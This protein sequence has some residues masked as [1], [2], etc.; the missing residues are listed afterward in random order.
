MN[1]IILTLICLFMAFLLFYAVISVRGILE[2]LTG[3]RIIR[4]D[5][6]AMKDPEVQELIALGKD[7]YGKKLAHDLEDRRLGLTDEDIAALKEK[8]KSPHPDLEDAP[9]IRDL[10]EEGREDEAVEVYQKFAGVDEYT[11]RDMVS[12]IKREMGGQ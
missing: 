3:K 9:G 5:K 12:K 11:A 6:Q 7:L 1:I 10:L 8:K 4:L 2:N